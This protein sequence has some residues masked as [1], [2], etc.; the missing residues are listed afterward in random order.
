LSE[1]TTTIVACVACKGG[2]LVAGRDVFDDRYGAPDL[3]RLVTCEDCGH[4]MTAPPLA[5]SDLPDLYS[6][7]YPRRDESVA[8]IQAQAARFDGAFAGLKRWLMGTDNQGQ[9]L[10][11]PGETI[12]DVGC[13]SGLSLLEAKALGAEPFGIEADPNVGPLARH[14]GVT[15]HIGNIFDVPFPERRFD[16]VAMNQVIEHVADPERTLLA[17]RER[18]AMGG[19][20]V[21]AFPNQQS[22]WRRIC[23]ERWL[24]WHIPFHLNH[25]NARS[26]R[27]L[28]E[29]CGYTV[30]R[31]RSVTP[32]VW[33]LM[34]LRVWRETPVRGVPSP[35]WSTA[36]AGNKD[37]SS[38]LLR[39]VRI[40]LLLPLITL[41][42]RAI[43]ALG[44]GDSLMFEL[45]PTVRP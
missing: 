2:R 5:E 40:V 8:A 37:L 28:A 10:A 12:L 27:L 20:L 7:Y 3:F 11:K 23:G 21:A 15:V 30:V 6:T 16:L 42:N 1:S 24:N 43:D 13:G 29:R 39:K 14:L 31:Q 22:F 33:T 45:K 35:T 38:R 25:F 36:A 34:Q 4:L 18:L 44:A 32:T 26:F 17:I 9:Y 19:R 41:I